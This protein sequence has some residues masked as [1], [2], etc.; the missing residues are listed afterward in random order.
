MDGLSEANFL[1]GGRKSCNGYVCGRE[2]L[3]FKD[4]FSVACLHL[5][6]RENTTGFR[7]ADRN[8][9]ECGDLCLQCITGLVPHMIDCQNGECLSLEGEGINCEGI[10]R[11]VIIIEKIV[12]LLKSQTQSGRPP[13]EGDFVLM[14]TSQDRS[15]LG[16]RRI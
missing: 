8:T 10:R 11:V 4:S 15:L 5:S 12:C 7:L 9:Q 13:C 3:P 6:R 16:P 2:K 14:V 1:Q